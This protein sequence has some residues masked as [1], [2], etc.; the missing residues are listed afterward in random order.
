[1]N[2]ARELI[3]KALKLK[4]Q[5]KIF[6]LEAIVESLDKSDQYIQEVW[7]KEAQARLI[8][9][10]AGITKGIP[11]EEVLGENLENYF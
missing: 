11:V 10:R 7:L 3:D 1:M 9:H 6:L 8:A 4:P 5:D 2:V